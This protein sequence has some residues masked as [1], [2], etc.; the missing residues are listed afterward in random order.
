MEVIMTQFSP[1]DD[2]IWERTTK[3]GTFM[4]SEEKIDYIHA[5]SR[6]GY[7]FKSVEG[8]REYVKYIAYE[9]MALFAGLGK[10]NGRSEKSK[11][12]HA[13]AQESF[14]KVKEGNEMQRTGVSN[15]V[16]YKLKR[17]KD[18]VPESELREIILKEN[19]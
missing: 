11:K 10:W 5:E 8:K 3:D 19:G 6:I 1:H 2:V 13:I 7:K 17:V 9:T 12:Y 14:R 16:Y 18:L 15:K 4:R